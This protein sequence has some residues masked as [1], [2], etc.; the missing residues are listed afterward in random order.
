MC[1]S[2]L[3]IIVKLKYL[4][5]TREALKATCLFLEFVMQ[6]WLRTTVLSRSHVINLIVICFVFKTVKQIMDKELCPYFYVPTAS[7]E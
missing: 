5:I 1:T 4:K 2:K 3:L 6:K 7:G